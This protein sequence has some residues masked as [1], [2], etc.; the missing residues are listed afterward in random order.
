MLLK[1]NAVGALGPLGVKCKVRPG[2]AASVG[3]WLALT[4]R[5]GCRGSEFK[6]REILRRDKTEKKVGTVFAPPRSLSE[7]LKALPGWPWTVPCC[8]RN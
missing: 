7:P 4:L 1:K 3:W 2:A 5:Q 6:G 8:F